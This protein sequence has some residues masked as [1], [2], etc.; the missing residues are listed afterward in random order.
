ELDDV[1]AREPSRLG[2]ALLADTAGRLWGTANDPQRAQVALLAAIGEDPLL[3]EPWQELVDTSRTVGS[4]SA[5]T[6]VASAWFPTEPTF[7][8][9]AISVRGDELPARLLDARLAYVLDP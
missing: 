4:T 2:R 9:K 1:R 7:L 6:S 3:V 5:I 8:E